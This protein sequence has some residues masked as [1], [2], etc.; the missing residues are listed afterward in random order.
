M[1]LPDF[2]TRDPD[3]E[4]RLTGHRVGLYSIIRRSREGRTAEQIAGQFPSLSAPQ[5][6]KVLDFYEQ[7]RADVDAYVDAYAAEL[8]RQAAA[9]RQGPDLA[10]LRRRWEEKGLGALP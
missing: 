4:V 7:N 6:A 5:V 1:N 2:L 9:L 10:E 3:G 8:Q